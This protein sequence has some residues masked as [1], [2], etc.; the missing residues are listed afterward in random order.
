MKYM[1]NGRGPALIVNG[2]LTER[3][4]FEIT[5]EMIEMTTLPGR[6]PD[7]TWFKLDANGHYHAFNKEGELPTLDARYADVRTFGDMEA[8][9]V[10][11]GWFCAICGEMVE[12]KYKPITPSGFTSPAPGRI[13]WGGEFWLPA[14]DAILSSGTQVSIRVPEFRRF[15]IAEITEADGES[16][17]RSIRYSYVGIGELAERKA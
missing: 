8:E 5:R 6:E 16:S 11:V 15:G 9:D 4:T 13:S 12:P 17:H 10:F 7:H 1:A 14:T 2:Q 3:A